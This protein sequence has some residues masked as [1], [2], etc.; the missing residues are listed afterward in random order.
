MD[1]TV[2]A[3]QDPRRSIMSKDPLF[4]ALFAALSILAL[5]SLRKAEGSRLFPFGLVA[6]GAMYFVIGLIGIPLLN[7]WGFT[8]GGLKILGIP[9][10]LIASAIPAAMLFG[11]IIERVRSPLGQVMVVG[12]FTL[13]ITLF[14]VLGLSMGHL[15]YRRWSVLSTFGLSGLVLSALAFFLDNPNTVVMG[16]DEGETR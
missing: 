2:N 14:D 11:G 3:I 1:T 16:E 10:F 13:A 9:V 6:G 8:P 15:V 7:L 5:T 12:A 4:I